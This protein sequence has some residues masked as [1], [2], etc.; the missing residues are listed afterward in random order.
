MDYQTY[1]A[2]CMQ[3]KHSLLPEAQDQHV[4]ESIAHLAGSVGTQ[5]S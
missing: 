4:A 2:I 5:A 3:P 1:H